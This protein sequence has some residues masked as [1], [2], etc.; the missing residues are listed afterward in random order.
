MGEKFMA[1]I[2]PLHS[3][4]F[5]G[6]PGSLIYMIAS[7]AMPVFSITGW[8]LYLDR[9]RRKRVSANAKSLASASSTEVS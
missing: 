4:S 9:R 1:S 3:G 5:F 8:M 7:L 6:V 2:F